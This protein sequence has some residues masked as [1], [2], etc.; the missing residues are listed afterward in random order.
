MYDND[1]AKRKIGHK[2]ISRKQNIS[3]TAEQH[4]VDRRKKYNRRKYY[5][6]INECFFVKKIFGCAKIKIQI[7]QRDDS[8][9]K[10][11]SINNVDGTDF[12]GRTKNKEEH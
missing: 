6:K 12:S 4:N 7:N 10:N 9:M 11:Y 8:E 2:I 1:I 5:Q 3:I